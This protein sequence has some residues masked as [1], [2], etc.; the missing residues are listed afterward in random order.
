M[1]RNGGIKKL[2]KA[3][4]DNNIFVYHYLGYQPIVKLFSKLIND[5]FEIIM[6]NLVAMEFLSYD[7]VETD[8]AVKN[9]RYQYINASTIWNIDFE[10]AEK[11]A[12]LRRKC[13]IESGKSLKAGDS[14]IAASAIIYNMRLYSNNDK[15][16][17]RLK[18]W[19]LDYVNPILNQEDL[20]HFLTEIRS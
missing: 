15:D 4:I 13:K 6:S 18:K 20:Q 2:N 17:L 7:K 14:L 10:I 9:K 3:L 12:E 16:F 11:A 19:G 1:K 8:T 5:D